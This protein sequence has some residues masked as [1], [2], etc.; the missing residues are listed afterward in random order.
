[1]KKI[2][3]SLLIV[4]VLSLAGTVAMADRGGFGRKEK[5]NRLK[6][7]I[8]A[9]SSLRNSIY[10]NLRSGMIFKGSQSISLQKSNNTIT[11]NS[12]LSYRKGN[13]LYILPYKQ[14]LVMPVYEKE[15]FK[16]VFRRK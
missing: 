4:I 7:G 14:R 10:L 13:T 1:M 9:P 5:K 15:G 11:D 6:F 3:N 16:L 12:I 2:T 8:S